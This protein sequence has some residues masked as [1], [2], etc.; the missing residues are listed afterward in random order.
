MLK[1]VDFFN[2]LFRDDFREVFNVFI[3]ILFLCYYDII[4]NEIKF[5]I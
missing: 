2:C 3:L 1:Y 4:N 5:D